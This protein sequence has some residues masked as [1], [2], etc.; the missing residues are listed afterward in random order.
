MVSV[1]LNICEE[2]GVYGNLQPVGLIDGKREY[3]TTL[4]SFTKTVF[5]ISGV[6]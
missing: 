1:R 2:E 5:R 6:L 3:H 4:L